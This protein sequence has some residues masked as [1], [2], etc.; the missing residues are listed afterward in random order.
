MLR[1]ADLDFD[2]SRGVIA[3][4]PAEPRDSARML[5]IRRGEPGR[6]EHR[7]VR[8]LPGLLRAGDTL[9]FN[10][11]R[12]IPARVEGR[13]AETGGV[14]QGLYLH[15]ASQ[16]RGEPAWSML[17][18]GRRLKPGLV[19]ELTGRDGGA[20]GV[21][22]VLRERSTDEPGAWLVDVRGGEGSSL[23]VLDTVGLPPLPPYIVGARRA[24]GLPERLD[25]DA[26]RY[27]TVYADAPGSVAAP[28][29]GLHFTPEL[30]SRL[31]G[32]GIGRVDVTLHVGAGTFRPVTTEFVE[33]HP[34]HAEW[35]SMTPA[36][37]ESIVRTRAIGGRVVCVGTTACR[38]VESYAAATAGGGDPPDRLLTRLLITP[39]YRWRATDGLLTNFH[40]PRTTLLALASA[41]TPGGVDRL[42]AIYA[43]A[44][45]AGYRFH[46]F[47]DAMLVLPGQI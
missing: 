10:T 18:E 32:A 23:D 30:L 20:S 1:T 37:W 28:T 38:T 3:T 39:G 31:R 17:I 34:I 5:V 13:R 6:I 35:C 19:V 12:V 47:G 36:A 33:D 41:A 24:S 8:D 11:S 9:V 4:S 16:D 14:V 22:L 26:E 29:A 7:F 27:Q 25:T 43:D 40:L 2:L 15:D 21:S 45:R 44:V 42:R 46:S